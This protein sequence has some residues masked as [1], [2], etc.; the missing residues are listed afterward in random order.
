MTL[1][2]RILCFLITLCTLSATAQ[3]HTFAPVGAVWHYDATSSVYR[4]TSE[5]DTVIKGQSCRKIIQRALTDTALSKYGLRLYDHQTIFVYNTEDTVFVYNGSRDTFT[6]L[7]VFNVVAGDTVNLPLVAAEC[8]YFLD[9]LN[10]SFKYVVDSVLIKD[11]DGQALKSVFGRA[12]RPKKASIGWQTWSDT[13]FIYAEVLGNIKTG[14]QPFCRGCAYTAEMDCG[15]SS[16]IRCYTSDMH[17]IKLR[18]GDC[19][20]GYSVS[21]RE[22]ELAPTN[23]HIYPNPAIHSIKFNGWRSGQVSLNI[24]NSMGREVL[25]QDESTPSIEISI[26]DW[27]SGLYYVGIDDG[28]QALFQGKFIKL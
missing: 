21:I 28:Q 7:Y 10:A 12:L 26:K 6:P 13:A 19:D 9:T 17:N 16:G 14:L 5:K 25:H 4:C 2:L 18:S 8:S 22:S 11:Y 27:P 23:V 15:F 20:R 24:Y 1:S 3:T